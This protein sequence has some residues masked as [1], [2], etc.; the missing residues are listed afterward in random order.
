F[1]GHIWNAVKR[2]GANALHG[3]VTGALS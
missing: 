1:W 3:A 2:V